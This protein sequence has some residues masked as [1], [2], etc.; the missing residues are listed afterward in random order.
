M[1]DN[2]VLIGYDTV[3]PHT[4]TLSDYAKLVGRDVGGNWEPHLSNNQGGGGVYCEGPSGF[5]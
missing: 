3:D 4:N 5:S 1:F 2:C